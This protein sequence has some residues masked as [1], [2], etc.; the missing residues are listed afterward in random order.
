[1]ILLVVGEFGRTQKINS[2]AGRD[3]WGKSGVALLGGGRIPGG[4][5]IGSTN[6]R[7]SAPASRPISPGD[8]WATVYRALGI[9]AN[10]YHFEDQFNRPFPVLSHGKPIPEL[11]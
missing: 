10:K 8:L 5:L 3:H 4:H 9:D 11:A 6:A 1:V 2:K 7:G